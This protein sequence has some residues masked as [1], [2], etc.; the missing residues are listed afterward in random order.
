[1]VAVLDLNLARE[2][3]P[4][5]M[6]LPLE[7]AVSECTAIGHTA[8]RIEDW[9]H[10]G[11]VK[12]H[13]LGISPYPN[14]SFP[15]VIGLLRPI[16]QDVQATAGLTYLKGDASSPRGAAPRLI[17]QIVNDSAFTWGGG[18]SLAIRRKWPV[19][20][21]AYRQWAS[22]DRRNLA[23]GNVHLAETND[24]LSIVS[25]IAQRG[26]GAS[27]KPRIRYSALRTCLQHLSVLATKQKATVHMPRI[28]TGLAGGS[29]NIISEL[30]DDVLCRAGINVFVYD[31]PGSA[32]T[33]HPAFSVGLYKTASYVN[34]QLTATFLY[35]P[36][37]ALPFMGS[38]SVAAILLRGLTALGATSF[39]ETNRAYLRSCFR[40]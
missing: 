17:A 5:G 10:A 30:I 37:I 3:V 26:Y 14:Q 35:N 23:L 27:D 24:K 38:V 33:R 28:G 36:F 7:S 31:L 18:F 13:C 21:Q 25:M 16:R 8:K 9:R 34:T 6:Q 29:W 1:M 39:G 2:R 4:P 20:Q 12:V 11:K 22:E 32:Q 19:A 40:R 15:R